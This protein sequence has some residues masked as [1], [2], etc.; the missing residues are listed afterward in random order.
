MGGVADADETVITRG[1]EIFAVDDAV[2][3]S[4]GGRLAL[5]LRTRLESHENKPVP[6]APSSSFGGSRSNSVSSPF[7]AVELEV[8]DTAATNGATAEMASAMIEDVWM[9]GCMDVCTG[10]SV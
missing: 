4:A 7:G 3:S 6:S 8:P 9:C 5:P 1:R 10:G 2:V